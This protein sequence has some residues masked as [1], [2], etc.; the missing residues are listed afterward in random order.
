MLDGWPHPSPSGDRTSLFG[1][2]DTK[3]Y[4]IVTVPDWRPEDATPLAGYSLGL[5]ES[6]PLLR[7]ANMLPSD[8]YEPVPELRT[9]AVSR[10][11]CGMGSV[12]W[13]PQSPRA[14]RSQPLPAIA[15]FVVLL[16]G[17]GDTVDDYA[18]WAQSCPIPPIIV[19]DAGGDLRPDDLNLSALQD[20]LLANCDR[21][22][23]L[24]EPK[25]I[26]D[27]KDHLNRW[28]APTF[29][30][31]DYTVDGHGTITPNLLALWSAGFAAASG[32]PFRDINS[33]PK[34]YLD[35]IV[36]TTNS[37]LD[38][39]RN[40]PES[41][42]DALFP[43]RPELS[44]FVPG[45]Y[46][47]ASV[48]I[49]PGAS[50]PERRRFSSVKIQ[51]ERQTGYNFSQ[52]TAA[53]IKAFTGITPEKLNSGSSPDL[54]WLIQLRQRE[55]ALANEAVTC[56]AGSEIS[57][58]ARLPFDLN[59][60]AGAVR[61]FASHYRGRDRR[62]T[63]TMDAF[64]AVQ[65]RISDAVPSEIKALIGRSQGE[66]RIIADAEIEWLDVDGVPLCARR[67]LSRIP[68]TPGNLFV[69]Q[70]EP[71]E[72]IRLTAGDF[73]KILVISALRRDDPI[74]RMLEVAFATFSK[75][76]KDAIKIEFV[77]VG[78]GD[79]LVAAL[80]AFDGAMVIFDG[81]GSHT[82]GKPAVLHLKD[83]ACDV[84][85]L[86]GRVERMPP[87]VILSA[88]DT[89]AADR[90]HATTAN[91]M[92]ALGARAVLSSVLPLD[93][94][95]AAMFTSRLIW[96]VSGYVPPATSM[97]DRPLSW[98]EV[99]GG[100]LRLQ[101][102]TDILRNALHKNLIDEGQYTELLHDIGMAVNT[103]NEDPFRE[104]HDRLVETGLEATR[105]EREA[106]LAIATSSVISYRNIGRPETILVDD[107]ERLQRLQYAEVE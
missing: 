12:D 37:L 90:N 53:Q 71:K 91:G 69:G 103:M 76:W 84:W 67:D 93:A 41:Q 14:I 46:D 74:A 105:V 29:E 44:L 106:R 32:E 18:L 89:H 59:R 50:P 88:C 65:N 95:A 22:D 47:L 52:T 51:L 3:I 99:V 56:L 7:S 10:R 107:E 58:V 83:E 30:N 104:L 23:G 38:L 16:V 97:L 34:P 60:T 64:R 80:N 20:R 42:G 73:A 36:A 57:A 49:K 24:V 4:Y 31:L 86:R 8:I 21:L 5:C 48:K 78:S 25:A 94:P 45:M 54:H 79:E 17:H 26:A 100:M 101:L 75:T 96:R 33:G 63:R 102:V 70:L 2:I 1:T 13:H 28:Q 98:T 85:S 82:P 72:T 35:Q 9:G 87:I 77:D 81:H 68:T 66:L 61:Q 62:P 43:R 39:R 27:A 6:I 15:P 11:M 19:A 55:V 40:T 92:L